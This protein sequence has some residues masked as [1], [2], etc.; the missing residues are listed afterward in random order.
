[1]EY[2]YIKHLI[3][4][5]PLLIFL[6]I[7]FTYTLSAQD[8]ARVLNFFPDEMPEFP[9]GEAA[10]VKFITSNIVY[11]D[12]SRIYEIQ[13][14]VVVRFVVQADGSVG[15]VEVLRHMDKYIDEEALR[16]IMMLP[17]FKPSMQQGKPVS[18]Q[19]VIPIMFK[20]P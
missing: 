8:T 6:L 5:R 14:K 18:T 11:P 13:G 20:L 1:M 12:S 16:V 9:G 10:L 19:M 17:K 2:L 3:I 7:S 15:K 4:M